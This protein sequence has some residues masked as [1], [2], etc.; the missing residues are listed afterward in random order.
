MKFQHRFEVQAPLEAVTEF[1]RQSASMAAITPPPV[2]VRIHSAP[3]E[4][5]EGDLMEFTLWVGP[6]PIRWLAQI[7][8]VTPHGF[9][10]RQISGP[11]AQWQH[12]H[13]FVADGNSTIVHDEVEAEYSENLFW[14][15]VGMGMW[16]N[17]RL[18]F[19]FRGWKTRR[20]LEKQTQNSS[21]VVE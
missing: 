5:G 7:E 1:H 12:T 20:L 14:R 9:V 8:N 10:D 21:K 3:E 15:L 18:L 16:L 19:A 11:F 2:I 4:L 17:M 6:L 13:T